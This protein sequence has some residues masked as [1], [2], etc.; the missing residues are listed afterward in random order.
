MR[1]GEVLSLFTDSSMLNFTIPCYSWNWK[2]KVA[3]PPRISTFR[4]RKISSHISP[5]CCCFRL[6]F[7]HAVWYGMCFGIMLNKDLKEN[8]SN[9]IFLY[10]ASHLCSWCYRIV[11]ICVNSTDSWGIVI[12]NS[13][14]NEREDKIKCKSSQ[15]QRTCRILMRQCRNLEFRF[16]CFLISF[17]DVF[18]RQKLFFSVQLNSS[19]SSRALWV[20]REKMKKNKCGVQ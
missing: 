6:S 7:I 12:R 19:V 3:P 10:F 16:Y 14:W 5:S 1:H 2:K 9:W 4:M 15:K 8:H 18:L 17:R 20:S 11:A 13:R